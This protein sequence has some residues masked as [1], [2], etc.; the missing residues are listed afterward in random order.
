MTDEETPHDAV[1]PL[2]TALTNRCPACERGYIYR[3]LLKL[4][5]NCPVCGLSLARHDS[6]D[7][8]AFFAITLLSFI[9][10]G[11]AA[12]IELRYKP[13]YY[14]H[15]L[16]WV[17]TLFALAPLALRFFKSYLL[18]WQYKTRRLEEEED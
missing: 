2:R 14:V 6:G 7:G 12:V 1:S 18:A 5:D 4:A 16:I 8:P 15:L 11:M 9:M 17:P 10:V 3:S 13:A